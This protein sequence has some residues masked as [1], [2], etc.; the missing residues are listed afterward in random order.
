ML[1]LHVAV[2][3]ADSDPGV[4]HKVCMASFVVERVFYLYVITKV[5]CDLCATKKLICT[6]VLF[7]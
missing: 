3:Q 5:V 4:R 6:C 2:S 1:H 7:T